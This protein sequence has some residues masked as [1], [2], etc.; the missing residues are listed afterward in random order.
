MGL[1]VVIFKAQPWLTL[2]LGGRLAPRPHPHSQAQAAHPLLVVAGVGR[3]LGPVQR[4]GHSCPA[5][6]WTLQVLPVL[7][8]VQEHCTDL[9]PHEDAGENLWK[10]MQKP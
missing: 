4:Q 1:R 10:Q 5:L 2:R 6:G 8:Q 9:L 3:P 7:P